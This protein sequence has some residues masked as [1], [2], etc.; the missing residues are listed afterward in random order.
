[1][2]WI[3][4]LIAGMLEI[5]WAVS[6]KFTHGFSRVV[7]SVVTVGLMAASFYFLALAVRELP[8][9]TAYAVWTGIGILGTTVIGTFF[10]W[11]SADCCSVIMHYI[12]H[13]RNY[14]AENYVITYC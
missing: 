6:L 14:R 8:L 12:C 1:M 3:F 7:P 4:L 11:R 13:N 9:G 2:K 10:F 5:S